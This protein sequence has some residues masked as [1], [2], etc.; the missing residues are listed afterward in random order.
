MLLPKGHQPV[1]TIEQIRRDNITIIVTVEIEHTE[2]RIGLVMAQSR[3]NHRICA[4][5]ENS[6]QRDALLAG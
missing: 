4:K 1:V 5:Q 2:D 6:C 3:H